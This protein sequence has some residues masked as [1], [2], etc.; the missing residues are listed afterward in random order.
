MPNQSWEFYQQPETGQ[1]IAYPCG[2]PALQADSRYWAV[3]LTNANAAGTQIG[4]ISTVDATPQGLINNVDRVT[5]V[6]VPNQ[7]YGPLPATF[8]AINLS[9]LRLGMPVPA[10]VLAFSAVT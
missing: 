9:N 8:P 3:V 6:L 4:G 10:V 1:S 2:G 5:G 7:T